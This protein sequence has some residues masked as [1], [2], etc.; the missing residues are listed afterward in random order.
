M[1][2]HETQKKFVL[3]TVRDGQVTIDGRQ[4]APDENHM[5][6]D[7]RLEGL[8]FAFGRY[9][10][11][12]HVVVLW[13]SEDAWESSRRTASWT[14]LD[15]YERGKC[16]CPEAVGFA[17]PWMFWREVSSDEAETP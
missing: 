3:R 14:D 8:R 13:G 10:H 5:T 6:Y 17:S 11:D 1:T 7:G 15:R 12:P 4:F 16:E 2:N 9:R